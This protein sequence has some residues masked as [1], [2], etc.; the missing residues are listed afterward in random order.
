MEDLGRIST[1]VFVV[2]CTLAWKPLVVLE[3]AEI[4]LPGGFGLGAGA[5]WLMSREIIRPMRMKG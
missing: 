4:E 5:A 1:S 3:S 2:D